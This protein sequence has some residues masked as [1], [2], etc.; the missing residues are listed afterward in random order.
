[1]KIT[2][3][4]LHHSGGIGAD[5]L[6]SSAHLTTFDIDRAHQGRWNFPSGI[7]KDP[8]DPEP[9]FV[10]YNFIIDPKNGSV[11]QCRAIGEETA[12]QQG[13][14]FDTI[15][16]CVIGN[17]S[18]FKENQISVDPMRPNV[19][20]ILTSLMD[21][22]IFG[23]TEKYAVLPGAELALSVAR[24]NPHRF[25]GQ[26]TCNGTALPDSWGRNLE[27][28]RI[29]KKIAI[30]EQLVKAYAALLSLISRRPAVGGI[31]DRECPGHI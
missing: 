25:Y 24:I 3:I 27:V 14:N 4:A 26:T 19:E 5:E 28:G 9:W 13:H 31:G 1:M 15:S 20:Q 29:S 30:I 6:A 12:A 16:I 7:R 21:D 23:R 8:L 17:Y 22:L 10:G 2:D 18:R 11:T